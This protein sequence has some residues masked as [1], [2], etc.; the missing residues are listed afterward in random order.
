M[1]EAQTRPERPARS[2]RSGSAA[3]ACRPSTGA[4]DERSRS[5]PS[6]AR[7]TSA[8]NFL[9]TADMYGPHTNEELVGRAIAAAAT[10]SSWRRSS[11]IAARPDDGRPPHRRPPRVRALGLRGQPAAARRRSHRPLLPAPRRPRHADRGDRRRDGGAGRGGQGAPPR[12]LGGGAE[13][14]R[15]AHAV[16]PITALQTEY[17]LW[18]RDIEDEILPTLRE[19]GIGLVAYSPLGRG[20]LTGAIQLARRPRRRTTSAA[21][22][23]A[24]RART[25]RATCRSSSASRSSRRRRACTPAQL[26]LA[27]VLARGD[28]IVPIPG[29]KRVSYL[30]ENLA[31]AEVQLS[32]QEV[33]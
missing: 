31:A 14:I 12:A 20:F 18:T 5:R 19:L 23:R 32:D 27:W 4:A 24:S 33:E 7:S 17:S 9:D 3:W 25:R 1:E 22:A 28:D 6:I 2:R 11:A 15:R 16:H 21:T 29:T 26:A 10:R 13:T 8:C 30:E